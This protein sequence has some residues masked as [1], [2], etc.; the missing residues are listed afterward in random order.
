MYSAI[1]CQSTLIQFSHPV[2]IFTIKANLAKVMGDEFSPVL[3]EL[4]PHLVKVIAQDEGQ[5]EQAEEEEVRT[6]RN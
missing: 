4:V 1:A 3:A 5:F 6:G 2:C